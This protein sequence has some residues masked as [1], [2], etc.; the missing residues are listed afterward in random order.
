MKRN[1]FTVID[2]NRILE[3]T[4]NYVMKNFS[5]LARLRINQNTLADVFVAQNNEPAE[6]KEKRRLQISSIPTMQ[7]FITQ[8]KMA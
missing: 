5:T 3:E 6:K 4:F 7:T 1:E 8:I 2:Y